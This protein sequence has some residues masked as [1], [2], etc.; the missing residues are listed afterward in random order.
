MKVLAHVTAYL[1]Q[2]SPTHLEYKSHLDVRPKFNM[3]FR[4]QGEIRDQTA[5]P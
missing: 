1:P 4:L 3:L 2:A 5:L